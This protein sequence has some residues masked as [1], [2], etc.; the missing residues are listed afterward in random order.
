MTTTAQPTPFATDLA[1]E[2]EQLKRDHVYKDRK[3]V[4]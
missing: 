4:V 2:L 3:S 1:E